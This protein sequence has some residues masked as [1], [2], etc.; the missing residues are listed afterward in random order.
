MYLSANLLCGLCGLLRQL[1]NLS[2]NN[3]KPAALFSR[4][5]GFNGSIERQQIG[6]CGYLMYCIHDA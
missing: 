6:L 4:T 1:A 2:G 5:S 3:G